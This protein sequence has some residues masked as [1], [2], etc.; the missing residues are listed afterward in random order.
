M[1]NPSPQIRIL[2]Q[3]FSF[4]KEKSSSVWS[5]DK[6]ISTFWQKKYL[7]I[8]K[9][10]YLFINLSFAKL[11]TLFYIF[12]AMVNFRCLKR[13]FLATYQDNIFS[14]ETEW[15]AFLWFP[16]ISIF[17]CKWDKPIY[18]YQ[19]LHFLKDIKKNQYVKSLIHKQ[20]NLPKPKQNQKNRIEDT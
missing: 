19:D 13:R 10:Y 18:R 16:Q 15:D 4:R 12:C 2:G 5:Y 17:S 9:L 7:Y 6:S 1:K 20:T 14:C 3:I 8:C 11:L